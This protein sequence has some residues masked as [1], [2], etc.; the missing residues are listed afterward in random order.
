MVMGQVRVTFDDQVNDV[1]L[2]DGAHVGA[3]GNICIT[4]A[5]ER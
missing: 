2:L 5:L 1:V 3:G 4:S